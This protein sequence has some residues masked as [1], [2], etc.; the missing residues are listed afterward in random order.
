MIYLF[1]VDRK[2]DYQVDS[3][4]SRCLGYICMYNCIVDILEM[5][6]DCLVYVNHC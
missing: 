5:V 2:L 3:K 1:D 4:Q 6:V